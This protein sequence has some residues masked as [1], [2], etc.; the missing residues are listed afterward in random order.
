[1]KFSIDHGKKNNF[2]N[3]IEKINK[4]VQNKE[5]FCFRASGR[6]RFFLDDVA[7]LYD[8]QCLYI[9]QLRYWEH[10]TL[11]FLY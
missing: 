8:L 9:L 10:F 3:M 1:M 11:V 7:V 6:V 2:T 5:Y 4:Q